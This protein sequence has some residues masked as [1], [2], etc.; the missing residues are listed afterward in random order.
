MSS[1]LPPSTPHPPPPSPARGRGGVRLPAR[2][3]SFRE[4][5]AVRTPF[6]PNWAGDTV[7][8]PLPRAG[9]GG[10]GWGVTVGWQHLALAAILLVAAGLDVVGLDR[11]AYGNTYY[12]AAVKSMLTSWH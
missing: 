11:E 4:G 5:A 3:R 8:P 6:S 12:A 7:A 10:G 1:V 9:E 2:D